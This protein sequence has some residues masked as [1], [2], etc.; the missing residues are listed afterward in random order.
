MAP[1]EHGLR[2]RIPFT[3]SEDPSRRAAG[4]VLRHGWAALARVRPARSVQRRR[5]VAMRP[6]VGCSG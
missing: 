3:R 4:R 1:E 5:S 2:L 6:D